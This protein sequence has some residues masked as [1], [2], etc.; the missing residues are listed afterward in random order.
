MPSLNKSNETSLPDRASSITIRRAASSPATRLTIRSSTAPSASDRELATTTPFPAARPSALMTTGVSADPKSPRLRKDKASSAES[1]TR[2]RAVGIRCRA[3]NSFANTLLASSRDAAVLG[4]TIG[5]PAFSKVS[6]RPAASGAS[7][8]TNVKSIPCDLAKF[9]NSIWLFT[10]IGNTSASCWMP[11][12]PGA[13]SRRYE[14]EEL[15]CVLR[16]TRWH[17]LYHQSRRLEFS[18]CAGCCHSLRGSVK[19]RV[20]RRPGRWPGGRRIGM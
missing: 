13:Q 19:V 20:L 9:S 4:P 10:L 2:K 11:A 15:K 7:G 8:P 5:N 12:L 14:V 6:T 1:A 16:P 17:V 18:F 3:M